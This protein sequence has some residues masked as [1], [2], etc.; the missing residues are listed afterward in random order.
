MA[1]SM[2]GVGLVTVSE[3]RLMV[4]VSFVV[5]RN[6]SYFWD[7]KA[8]KYAP[9]SLRLFVGCKSIFANFQIQKSNCRE[10]FGEYCGYLTARL[11]NQISA[12]N[13]I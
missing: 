12:S 2:P 3:R 9:G 5:E 11:C 13:I 7:S 4:I 6:W 8:E 10:K 1:A